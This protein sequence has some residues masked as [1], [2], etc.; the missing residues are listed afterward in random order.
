MGLL[1]VFFPRLI[2]FYHF[3]QGWFLIHFSFFEK[4]QGRFLFTPSPPKYTRS[5]QV[6]AFKISI[7]EQ[8]SNIWWQDHQIINFEREIFFH[9][10][11]LYGLMKCEGQMVVKE[12]DFLSFKRYRNYD[13]RLTTKFYWKSSK[14]RNVRN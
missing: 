7:V 10:L 9:L 6:H 8:L 2:D 14:R 12:T 4:L 1:Y 11:L 13:F 5:A 3:L